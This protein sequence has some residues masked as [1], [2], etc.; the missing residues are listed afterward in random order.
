M[1]YYLTKRRIDIG[2]IG[3]VLIIA[4][5][6]RLRSMGAQLESISSDLDQSIRDSISP[7]SVA[8]INDQKML[9]L[10]RNVHN[11]AQTLIT[12]IAKLSL[13]GAPSK[14]QAIKRTYK[15]I[16]QK[17]AIEDIRKRLEQHQKFLENQIIIDLR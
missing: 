16:R 2:Q 9:T 10:S 13:Q 15:S 7:N 3:F 5:S 1:K 8:S 4:F 11:T 14:R 6:D 17:R 12:E